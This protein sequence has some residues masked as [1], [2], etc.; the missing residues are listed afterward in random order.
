[1]RRALTLAALTVL[2][3]LA[4]LWWTGAFA[5]I[6][7]WAANQQRGFQN[8]IATALRATRAG[9][10]GAVVALLSACF[11]YGVVHAAGPGHGKVLIGGYG[12]AKA[13]PMMRLALIA[14]ASSMGQAV[15]AVALVYA[16]VTILD[17]GR[18]AMVGV[19]EAI[20]A[21]VSYG[22]IGL[23]GLWLAWRGVKQ[24]RP[25]THHHHHDD[26]VCPSCGHAHG[27]T[28]AQMD[29]AQTLREVLILIA[30]IAIR[31]CTG[32]LFVLIITWQMGIAEIGIAGVFAMA[33]GTALITIAVGVGAGALRSGVLAG[34]VNAPRAAALAAMIQITAGSFVAVLA[35]GLL[36]R[37]L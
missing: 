11:A 7:Y 24:V 17:L 14:L 28:A 22:A 12:M 4:L 8:S 27:P 9:E 6:G 19:T 1:M 31:P 21:P 3:A 32:A 2:I 10:T 16:G 18:E 30:S 29:E 33:F 15:T 26:T 25:A 37:A 23:V 5:Q 34:F 36:F 20:M 35:A 13:V